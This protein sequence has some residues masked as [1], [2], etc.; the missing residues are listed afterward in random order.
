MA[1]GWLSTASGIGPVER[2]LR[3]VGGEIGVVGGSVA[4]CFFIFPLAYSI[5][6]CGYELAMCHLGG[7]VARALQSRPTQRD[8]LRAVWRGMRRAV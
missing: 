4:K 2:V 3:R 6:I 7:L 1:V 8:A 5:D